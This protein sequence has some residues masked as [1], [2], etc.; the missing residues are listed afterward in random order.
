MKIK[1]VGKMTKARFLPTGNYRKRQ[2][3]GRDIETKFASW[4]LWAEAY[5]LRMRAIPAAPLERSDDAVGV[6]A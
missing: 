3:G 5:L 1:V 4:L 2:Q 6:A